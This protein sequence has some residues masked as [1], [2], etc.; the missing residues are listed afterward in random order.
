MK[1]YI[2]T[3][4]CLLTMIGFIL[5]FVQ[6]QWHPFKLKP[7]S[8]VTFAT[9]KPEL[10][11]KNFASGKY[12]SQTEQYSREN[13]GFREWAIRL[14]NQ[15][16]YSAYNA[17]TCHFIT[18][19][20]DGWLFYAEAF[21]DYY[22]IEPINQ[23]KTYDRAREWAGKNVRMMNKL[24]YVLKDYGIEFLC[25]M[26]PNKAE[27]YPEYLP[28]H[29]P[30]PADAIHT[31]A[32][33]DSLMTAIDFPHV[34]M[35]KWY[36]SMK[37][38][39]SFLLFPKR[40]THWRYSAVYGYDSLFSYMN[41]LNGFGIP[42]IHIDR[43]VKLD[44]MYPENDELTLN[45]I[46]PIGNDSP[47]YRADI[48][49]D[50]GRKPKVLFV[51]DSFVW[52]LETYMPWK[53]FL[54][55]VEIWFYN[56]SAFLGFEKEKHPIG[57][58]NRLRSILNADYVVWYSSGYQW[59]LSSYDFVEDALLRLCVTDS[60][61]D[62]Q[63]PWVMD[64]LRNDSAFKA[65]HYDWYHPEAF[66]DTLRHYAVKT[67]RDNPE[68][69]PGLD[70]EAMPTIRN[71]Q[72]IALAQQANAIANDKPWSTALRLQASRTGRHF[73][74]VLDEEAENVLLSRPLMRDEIQVDTASVIEFEVNKLKEQWRN[75]PESIKFLEDKA[76]E[77]GKTFE[78]VLEEDARWVINERLR[79]G[80]LF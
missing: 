53:E 52:D 14:Y 60:L 75:N 39:A 2:C 71:T 20:K 56:K 17:T 41:S 34:E 77:N 73:D 11:L 48:S 74:D 18:P 64:S 50:P 70:G 32:Y 8:G 37:D 76:Q 3:I 4:L 51:G 46:F 27:V 26:A 58:I 57:D 24:R 13:F 47:K 38:T 45:L 30:A 63:I 40:D 31:A 5:V 43:L 25:F 67:L 19:G 6:E 68:L 78:T 42:D 59:G 29:Q 44:T 23:Y 62:A 66:P 49:V 61:F 9:E 12:Q 79:N 72:A 1:R 16:L 69:I 65:Q 28:Y 80:E 10:N 22:G 36:Q 7:L 54:D 21:R 33:Y 15:Y 55:Y 35:T